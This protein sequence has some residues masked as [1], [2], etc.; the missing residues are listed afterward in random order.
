MMKSPGWGD[1]LERALA[2]EDDLDEF[3]DVMQCVVE[4]GLLPGRGVARV[5]Y[6]PE[7]GD[8]E[9]DPDAEPD[10]QTGERPTFRPVE[11]ERAPVRY[12]FWED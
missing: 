10:E 6:E 7:Y 9:E 5:Y 2:Y 1:D 4:D 3:D 11:S 12:I 8:P